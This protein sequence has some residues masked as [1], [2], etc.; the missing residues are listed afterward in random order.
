ML[1]KLFHKIEREGIPSD[2]LYEHYPDTKTEQG[3]SREENYRPISQMNIDAKIL[4][5]LHIYQIA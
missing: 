3:S 1:L 2:S 5:K 4:N